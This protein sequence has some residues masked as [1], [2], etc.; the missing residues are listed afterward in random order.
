MF[1][2]LAL[3]SSKS[4]AFCCLLSPDLTKVEKFSVTSSASEN[5]LEIAGQIPLPILLRDFDDQESNMWTHL[6]PLH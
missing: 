6:F 3:K 4:F 1:S 5:S 2:C